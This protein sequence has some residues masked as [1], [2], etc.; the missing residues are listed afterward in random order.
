[1][2]IK[3]MSRKHPSFAQ[4]IDYIEGEA[5]LKSRAFSIHHL[6]PRHGKPQAGI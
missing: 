6:Q 5:K 2:I 1:M 4:L 3:S